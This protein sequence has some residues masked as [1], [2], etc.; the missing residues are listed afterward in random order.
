MSFRITFYL[1][2]H[3]ESEN[4][5]SNIANSLPEEIQYHL[6]KKGREQVEET[7]M[8]LAKNGATAIFASPLLRTRETAEIISE[9]TGLPI[10]FDER[11]C[12]LGNGIFNNRPIREFLEK[13]P[14]PHM[15]V[16]PD[17]ADGVESLIDMRG[18]LESFLRDVEKR[19]PEGKIIVVSHGDPLEQFHGILTNE[20]PGQSAS[21]WMPENASHMEVKWEAK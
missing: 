19:Y 14:D 13:Y 17:P 12:E 2:R 11:L 10:V 1:V 5:V 6:T 7:A 21:G 20:S 3:G 18:R 8:L 9:K 16:S 15:R 4:N